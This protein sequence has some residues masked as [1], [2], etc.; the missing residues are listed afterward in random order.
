MRIIKYILGCIG[1]VLKYTYKYRNDSQQPNWK[2]VYYFFYQR[3]LF[4]NIHVPWICHPTSYVT[5]TKNIKLG[6]ETTPGSAPCQYINGFNG[7]EMG[8]NVYIGPG[9]KIISANHDFSNYKKHIKSKPV[10]IGDNVWIGANAVILPSVNVGSNVVIGAGSI[11]TKDIPA[12]S[13]AFGN[14]CKV[15]KTKT[16]YGT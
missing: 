2:Y 14:P 4:F 15:Q 5:S 8:N 16:E 9:V 1:F 6:K 10:I 13:I 12:N 3:I 7:I 11:V